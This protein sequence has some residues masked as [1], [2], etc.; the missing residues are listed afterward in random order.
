[1]GYFGFFRSKCKICSRKVK[2][3][4]TYI[5]DHGEEIKSI[6]LVQNMLSVEPTRSRENKTSNA[7]PSFT[8]LLPLHLNVLL[9]VS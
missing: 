4:R 7:S 1:M 8:L 6:S 3:L 9:L 5:N 2:R